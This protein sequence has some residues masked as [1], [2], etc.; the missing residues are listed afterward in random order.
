M[1]ESLNYHPLHITTFMK[2]QTL[3][4]AFLLQGAF[5]FAQDC[6]EKMVIIESG[7][8]E[9]I[10]HRVI[11]TADNHFILAGQKNTDALVIKMD[12]CGNVLWERTHTFGIEAA[13]RDIIE[14]NNKLVAMGYCEQCRMNDNSRKL[15]LHELTNEG[16]LQGF[17]KTLGPTNIDTDAMRMRA[18]SNGR[19][20]VVGSRVITQGNVSGTGMV[21]YVLT[22]DLN[23]EHSNVF[24][25]L[26][27]NETAYDMVEIPGQGYVIVGGSMQTTPSASA[28]IR[29]IGTNASLVQTWKQELHDAPTTKEQVGRSVRRL[30]HGDLLLVGTRA[31]GTNQQLYAATLNPTNGAI[32]KEA[33]FGG[34]GDDVGRDVFVIDN[35]NFF[36]AGMRSQAGFNDNPWGLILDANLGLRSEMQLPQQGFFNSGLSFMDG[37]KRHFVLAGTLFS[38]PFNGIWARTTD[39]STSVDESVATNQIRIFPNPA[40][41]HLIL[42]GWESLPANTTAQLFSINGHLVM[43]KTAT[44]RLELPTLPAGTYVLRLTWGEGHWQSQVILG[45]RN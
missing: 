9:V 19:F 34:S 5:A 24:T 10:I 11:R 16:M 44:P 17:I 1:S 38:F 28:M 20:G 18:L 31:V 27:L 42:Q 35:D 30:D 21:A 45:E 2:I 43:E 23:T 39:V 41:D 13:F 8:D 6:D 12:A 37:G 33:T 26:K 3:I 36:I 40:V 4:L 14:V 7:F 29:V 25:L 15:L 22:P 32:K